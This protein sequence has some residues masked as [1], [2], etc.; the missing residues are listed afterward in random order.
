M[1]VREAWGRVLRY[2][3]APGRPHARVD[4]QLGRPIRL[5]PAQTLPLD[6]TLREQLKILKRYEL[7][8]EAASS[9]KAASKQ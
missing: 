5:P 3:K 2:T 7:L 9:A 1:A 8:A 4:C 6:G